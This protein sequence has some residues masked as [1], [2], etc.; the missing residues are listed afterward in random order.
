MSKHLFVVFI[1]TQISM[2]HVLY[3]KHKYC[4]LVINSHYQITI[5]YDVCFNKLLICC[6]L[7]VSML[8]VKF[9]Y[10]VGLRDLEYGQAE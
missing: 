8:V 10:M 6:L 4:S 1:I 9:S 3:L 2:L 5:N 7:V